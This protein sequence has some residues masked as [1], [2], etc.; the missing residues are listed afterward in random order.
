MV[1][2]PE[3][4]EDFIIPGSLFVIQIAK[5]IENTGRVWGMI[6]FFMLEG[7]VVRK[8]AYIS[9]TVDE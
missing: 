7:K 8:V 5:K 4:V 3:F 9:T 2:I 1:L 6:D